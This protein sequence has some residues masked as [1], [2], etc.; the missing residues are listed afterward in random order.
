MTILGTKDAAPLLI[1]NVAAR[2]LRGGQQD[3]VG[4]DDVLDFTERF[5][6]K[7]RYANHFFC[8]F[9]QVCRFESMSLCV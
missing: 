2:D 4:K 9:L 1:N 3:Q 8:I 6:A 5:P 7:L